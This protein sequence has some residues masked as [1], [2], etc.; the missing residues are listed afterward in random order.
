MTA[1][2]QK[3]A[4]VTGASRGIGKAIALDLIAQDY[5]IIALSRGKKGLEALDDEIQKTLGAKA[6]LIPFDLADVSGFASLQAALYERFGKIDLLVHAAAYLGNL[7]PIAHMEPKDFERVI[8]TNLNGTFGLMQAC[9][10]LLRYSQDPKAIF[11]QLPKKL[12][13]VRPIGGPM[14]RLRRR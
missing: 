12:S 4:L 7:I 3:I 2:M 11:L 8:K 10:P 9:E 14:V 1:T 5:H 13:L 6:S